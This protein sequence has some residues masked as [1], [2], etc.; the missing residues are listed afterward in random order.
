VVGAMT[1]RKTDT[2][3]VDLLLPKTGTAIP[4]RLRALECFAIILWID[5][6]F[7]S[8]SVAG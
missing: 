4:I 5:S 6:D 2:G 7:C 1:A 8:S 3:S